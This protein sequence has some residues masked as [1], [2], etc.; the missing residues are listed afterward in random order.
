LR[1]E[2]IAVRLKIMLIWLGL[3][4][5]KSSAKV[6]NY[7][8]KE[9]WEGWVGWLSLSTSLC[10]CVCVCVCVHVCVAYEWLVRERYI[11]RIMAFIS[12]VPPSIRQLPRSSLCT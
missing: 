6:A 12:F 11:M 4:M 5:S 8:S 9:G 1:T 7:E 3:I 10:L 2:L